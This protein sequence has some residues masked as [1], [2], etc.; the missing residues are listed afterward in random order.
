MIFQGL[1]NM[2]ESSGYLATVEGWTRRQSLQHWHRRAFGG[3]QVG[4]APVH[5]CR[6]GRFL[7][8]CQ[9]LVALHFHQGTLVVGWNCGGQHHGGAFRG[10]CLGGRAAGTTGIQAAV[11]PKAF[12]DE[13]KGHRGGEMCAVAETLGAKAVAPDHSN[14]GNGAGGV[15][16]AWLRADPTEGCE[17]RAFNDAAD[18]QMQ[19]LQW[20]LQRWQSEADGPGHVTFFGEGR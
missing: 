10:R 7:P 13:T 16:D 19:F 5:Q 8:R 3:S 11:G 4:M 18:E 20:Y 2:S 15:R 17:G 9:A 1:T 6:F 14:T 12:W